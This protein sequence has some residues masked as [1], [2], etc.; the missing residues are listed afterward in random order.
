LREVGLS[1]F[2]DFP[3]AKEFFLKKEIDQLV[4]FARDIIHEDKEKLESL[5]F[6]EN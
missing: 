6:I 3:R 4:T 5:S 2:F 1:P